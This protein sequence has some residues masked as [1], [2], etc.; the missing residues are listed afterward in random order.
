MPWRKLGRI[1][2]PDQ[3]DWIVSHAQVPTAIE[4][5][6]FI[7]VYFSPRDVKG[8]AYIAYIDLD[9]AN[10]FQL[11]D[12]NQGCVL[13]MGKPGTFDE[14]GVMPGFV[15]R[16]GSD[17]LMYYSGWNQKVSTPYHNATGLAVSKDGGITFNRVY[18]GPIMDRT[19]TEPYVAVT[20]TILAHSHGY[21]MWYI[22]GI[23]WEKFNDKYEPIY[24]IKY[25]TSTDGHWW[26]RDPEIMVAQ[27]HGD[28]AFSHPTVVRD[29]DRFHMWYC[30]RGSDDYRD[31]KNAYRIGYAYSLNAKD[32]QRED[33][34]AGIDASSSGWDSTMICYP[35]VLDTK[36]GRIMF[37]NGNGFG[38]TGIGVA[39]WED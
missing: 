32:W 16:S 31:G 37:H 5:N 2:D 26:T 9:P 34:N 29:E 1:F 14:D 11:L 7:R 17:H 20:P 33:K 38:I 10:G 8:R 35:F 12:I 4:F 19:A 21:Q 22:S 15:M 27:R 24:V 39:T 3:Q 30:Y 6:T 23:R 28:E 25:A 13:G 18:D 36:W